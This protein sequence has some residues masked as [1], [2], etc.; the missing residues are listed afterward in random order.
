MAMSGGTQAEKDKFET[1]G[2]AEFAVFKQRNSGANFK[3]QLWFDKK[4]RMFNTTPTD[5]SPVKEEW[6][7][8]D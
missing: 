4:T 6:Y 3:R 2:D 7:L 8:E 1:Q 5:S